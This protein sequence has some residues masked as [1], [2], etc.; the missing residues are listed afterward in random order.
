M[1]VCVISSLVVAGR[2]AVSV[3]S[4]SAVEVFR[5][6]SCAVNGIKYKYIYCCFYTLQLVY[7]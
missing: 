7:K 4:S 3:P 1:R 6:Q 5:Q 2:L